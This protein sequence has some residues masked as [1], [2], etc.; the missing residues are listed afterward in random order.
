MVGLEKS[1]GW[2]PYLFLSNQMNGYLKEEGNEG[3]MLKVFQQGPCLPLPKTHFHGLYRKWIIKYSSSE[4]ATAKTSSL[5][6]RL[7]KRE[8][9]VETLK[10]QLGKKEF[11]KM[12]SKLELTIVQQ[13]PQQAPP[14]TES[15]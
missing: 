12:D 14:L 8:Y 4:Q 9:E 13:Q 3:Y 5:L 6:E 15:S 10:R 7:K 11:G 1:V 2:K